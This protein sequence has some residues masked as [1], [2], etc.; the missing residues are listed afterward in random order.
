MNWREECRNLHWEAIAA[1]KR[2][3]RIPFLLRAYDQDGKISAPDLALK[4]G[5]DDISRTLLRTVAAALFRAVDQPAALTQSDAMEVSQPKFCAYFNLPK[6]L[7]AEQ[8]MEEY[9][10]IVS[11]QFGGTM[12]NLPRQLWSEAIIT[13]LKGPKIEPVLFHTAYQREE[14][15]GIVFGKTRELDVGFDY[16]LPDWWDAMKQ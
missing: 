9:N 16:L 11:S 8:Y 4:D 14:E 1:L 2:D 13:R 3:G 5:L 7:R 6:T 15:A 12:A 10:R